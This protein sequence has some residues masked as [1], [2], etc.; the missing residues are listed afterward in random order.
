MGVSFVVWTITSLRSS[1]VSPAT[2]KILASTFCTLNRPERL[3]VSSLFWS[4]WVVSWP[5]SY[6]LSL[7][8]MQCS[9]SAMSVATNTS[10]KFFTKACSTTVGFKLK[11]NLGF[12]ET[13]ENHSAEASSRFIT[14]K[15]F[16]LSATPP[17]VLAWL[18]SSS[19]RK[20]F[21]LSLR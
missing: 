12:V 3:I 1:P 21:A 5:F 9:L 4:L 13:A 2:V 15:L 17:I 7:A 19:L 18:Y 14:P 11:P 8:V 20:R 10:G 6:I 16:T